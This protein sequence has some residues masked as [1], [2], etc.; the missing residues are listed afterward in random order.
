MAVVPRQSAIKATYNRL[1]TRFI[2]YLSTKVFYLTA[3]AIVQ[4]AELLAK[5]KVII[6]SRSCYREST[7][8]YPIASIA[9]LKK[10]LK[11]QNHD[12]ATF[13]FIGELKE[14]TRSV[15]SVTVFPQYLAYCKQA[16]AVV[17]ASLLVNYAAAAPFVQVK[18]TDNQFF[19]QQSAD[20]LW[21]SVLQ[22]QLIDT[23]ERAKLALGV[24]SD[25]LTSD[26]MFNEPEQLAASLLKI[27]ARFWSSC[28]LKHQSR[29]ARFNPKPLVLAIAVFGTLYLSATSL[30]LDLTIDNRQ[31]AFNKL[32][33]ETEVI[34][35]GRRQLE[36]EQAL[37]TFLAQQQSDPALA[38]AFWSVYASWQLQDIRLVSVR[39]D[40]NEVRLQGEAASATT[41]LQQTLDLPYV[42][43]ASFVSPVRRGAQG[44]EVFTLVLTL[45][46]AL[47]E[48]KVIQPDGN[49]EQPAAALVEETL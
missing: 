42:A 32:L 14:G 36:Q 29:R 45:N 26:Y 31:Q 38:L 15:I 3:Q 37:L 22:S 18:A 48:R 8:S 20:G 4:N 30:Y 6:L 24:A 11:Q 5:A 16:W 41:V 23:A 2:S 10:I 13:H 7:S 34:S 19:I 27:P 1:K 47:M 33:V 40:F 49:P 12:E 46:R 25:S 35:T 9:E 17:P 44:R 39:S 28:I 43:D 21:H